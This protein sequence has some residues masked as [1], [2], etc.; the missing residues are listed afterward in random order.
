MILGPIGIGDREMKLGF[1]A[2]TD[3]ALEKLEELGVTVR[4]VETTPNSRYYEIY[5]EAYDLREQEHRDKP[6]D[7][8]EF[9]GDKREYESQAF[10]VWKHPDTGIYYLWIKGVVF[11][12]FSKLSK[13]YSTD[14]PTVYSFDV[15][16]Y[17]PEDDSWRDKLLSIMP[18][19]ESMFFQ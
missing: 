9:D 10:R 8:V 5:T 3:E 6:W 12:K 14:P 4:R 13:N 7:W 11:R 19:A 17:E 2:V 15:F 1:N 16:D 18:M